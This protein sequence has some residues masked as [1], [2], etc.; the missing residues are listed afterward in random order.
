LRADRSALERV[1]RDAG[2]VRHLDAPVGVGIRSATSRPA[3][4]QRLL[5]ARA[6]GRHAGPTRATASYGAKPVR[7]G[8]ACQGASGGQPLE[9]GV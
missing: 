8:Q 2:T 9:K 6:P 1:P 5:P 3:T 7:R 4:L